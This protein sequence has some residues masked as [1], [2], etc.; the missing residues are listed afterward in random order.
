MKKQNKNTQTIEDL[1]IIYAPDLSLKPIKTF[2][3]TRRHRFN[4]IQVDDALFISWNHSSDPSGAER[5]IKFN[6][7]P[8]IV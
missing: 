8:S 5:H 2:I 4:L 3:M 7:S 1:P 6:W